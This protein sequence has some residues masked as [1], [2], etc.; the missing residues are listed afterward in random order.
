MDFWS[1]GAAA[2]Q[3]ISDIASDMAAGATGTV[4]AELVLGYIKKRKNLALSQLER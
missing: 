4:L 3:F 2:L 1:I